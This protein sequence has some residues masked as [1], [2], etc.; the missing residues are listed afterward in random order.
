LVQQFYEEKY[1]D[2]ETKKA[3]AE[4]AYEAAQTLKYSSTEY[5]NQLEIE[6][7]QEQEATRKANESNL[8][9]D[10]VKKN[11]QNIEKRNEQINIDS[12]LNDG[13]N[14]R[15]PAGQEQPRNANE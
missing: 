9:E 14:Q 4:L 12:L 2:L 11:V 5:R 1:V 15:G 10:I 13:A 6:E 8:G 7:R 3:N